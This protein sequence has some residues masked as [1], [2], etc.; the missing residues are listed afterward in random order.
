[1]VDYLSK[2]YTRV[3]AE[4][5]RRKLISGRGPSGQPLSRAELLSDFCRHSN[6]HGQ[7]ATALVSVSCRIIDTV[8]RAFDKYYR[9]GE[10]AAEIWIVFISKPTNI[11]GEGGATHIHAAQELAEACD[12]FEYP[13]IFKY[14]YLVEW[15]IPESLVVHS[16]SLQTLMDRGLNWYQGDLQHLSEYE[17][18]VDLRARIAA[19]IRRIEHKYGYC[20]VGIYLGSFASLFGARAPI[21]WVAHQLLYDCAR[22]EAVDDGDNFRL[23]YD[24]DVPT[25]LVDSWSLKCVE[26]G[27]DLVIIDWWFAME[28]FIIDWEEFENVRFEMEYNIYEKIEEFND[29]WGCEELSEAQQSVRDRAWAGL[30][31]EFDRQRVALEKGAIEKGF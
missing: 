6:R 29:T 7:E 8:R 30:C 5:S 20:D 14:E 13:E 2:M 4:S 12:G 3:Y 24:G 18:T 17:P 28:E 31:A 16:V 19:D 21:N 22:I 25:S 27:I 9:D 15:A 10:P 1:M 23:K 26:D 11:T